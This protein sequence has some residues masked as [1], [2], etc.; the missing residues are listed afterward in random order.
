MT[1]M[2]INAQTCTMECIPTFGR[3]LVDIELTAIRIHVIF[4]NLA[5]EKSTVNPPSTI[6]A[7]MRR[8]CKIACSSGAPNSSRTY[9]WWHDGVGRVGCG[10]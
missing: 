4:Q 1:L 2:P 3:E 8:T 9:Q 10:R 5:T 7:I 6:E